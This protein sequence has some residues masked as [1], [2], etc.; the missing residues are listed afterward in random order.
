MTVTD[1]EAVL[2]GVS[3]AFTGE[4]R[5]R[6]PWLKVNTPVVGIRVVDALELWLPRER[7]RICTVAALGK[8]DPGV[9]ITDS[10]EIGPDGKVMVELATPDLG[11]K[12]IDT[13]VITMVVTTTAETPISEVEFSV[14]VSTV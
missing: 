14:G 11:G 2:A 13:L 8:L 4:P 1:S 12:I 5:S 10:G 7:V 3:P 6:V 9:E